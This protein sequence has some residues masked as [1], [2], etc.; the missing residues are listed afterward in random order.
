[1]SL[2]SLSL[3]LALVRHSR[4]TSCRNHGITTT[5]ADVLSLREFTTNAAGWDTAGTESFRS[6]T[7][8]YFR[9]AAG[10]LLVYDVTRRESE[11]WA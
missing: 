10:A 2:S 6:I 8:S 5:A 3:S 7:R 11:C 1:M 9:G 4:A